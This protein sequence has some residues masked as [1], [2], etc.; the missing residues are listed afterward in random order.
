MYFLFLI[1]S[2][3]WLLGVLWNHPDRAN[4]DS[5]GDAPLAA[6]ILN[7]AGEDAPASGGLHDG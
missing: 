7:T 5:T 3:R 2:I 6:Q 1:L 4:A